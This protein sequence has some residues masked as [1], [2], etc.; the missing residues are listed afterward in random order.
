MIFEGSWLWGWAPSRQGGANTPFG[1]PVLERKTEK[2][3]RVLYAKLQ[4]FEYVFQRF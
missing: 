1:S 4:V 2:I 3:M